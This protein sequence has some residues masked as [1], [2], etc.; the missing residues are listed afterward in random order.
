[1]R[2]ITKTQS[3]QPK[4]RKLSICLGLLCVT[5]ILAFAVSANAQNVTQLNVPTTTQLWAGTRGLEPVWSVVGDRTY[6]RRCAGRHGAQPVHQWSG[7]HG[8]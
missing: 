3:S 7:K 2:N 5:L 8:S 1:M 6:G 4:A